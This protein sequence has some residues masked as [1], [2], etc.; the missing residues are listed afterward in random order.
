MLAQESIQ[1]IKKYQ[2]GIYDVK[3]GK[4]TLLAI[5]QEI[6]KD[7]IFNKRLTKIQDEYIN[8][9]VSI[10]KRSDLYADSLRKVKDSFQNKLIEAE[11]ARNDWKYLAE[12]KE[13]Q[14]IENLNPE[15]LGKVFANIF[16]KQN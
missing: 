12:K 10:L 3:I 8:D 13:E 4:D 6:Q 11:K 7:I 5:T 2:I 9:L 16:S 14:K 15:E 1:V